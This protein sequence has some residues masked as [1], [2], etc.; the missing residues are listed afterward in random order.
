MKPCRLKQRSC[1][2]CLN[3]FELHFRIPCEQTFLIFLMR[4]PL[5]LSSLLFSS[6]LR[7]P[8]RDNHPQL[9]ISLVL[10][11]C[12]SW[13]VYFSDYSAFSKRFVGEGHSEEGGGPGGEGTLP[14]A[15]RARTFRWVWGHSSEIF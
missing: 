14:S 12:I 13:P 9:S 7:I 2:N 8:L 15:R 10:C 3:Q 4:A 11:T 1:K 5:L 6:L